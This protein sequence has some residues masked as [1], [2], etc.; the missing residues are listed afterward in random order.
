M[1][2]RRPARRGRA[3]GR[4]A[5]DAGRRASTSG[6][7]RRAAGAAARRAAR[8]RASAPAPSSRSC[9]PTSPA[10]TRASLDPAASARTGIPHVR[11][12]VPERALT[13]WIVLDVSASMAFGTGAA[14][15]VRRRRGRRRRRRPARGAPRRAASRPSPPARPR[16]RL[17][18]PRS[19]RRA[20]ASL[21][22]LVGAG[23]APDG[24]RRRAAAG[25]RARARAAAS[26]ARAGWSPSS[27][28][29]ATTAGRRR[30]A[31]SPSATP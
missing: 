28:T 27:P 7:A 10:T 4:C 19:G 13:T 3:P 9:G 25:R 31:R 18:P 30:C 15:E 21:R 8:A 12:H 16:A 29:S 26:R 17:L 6:I 23:V 24:A 22:R 1:T 5:A 2:L 20:F 11:Q 14:P